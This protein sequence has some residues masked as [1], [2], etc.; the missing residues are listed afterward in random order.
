MYTSLGDAS[1]P[2]AR[3]YRFF[4]HPQSARLVHQHFFTICVCAHVGSGARFCSDD[5]L[6]VLRLTVA[7]QA[8][9][10]LPA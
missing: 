4:C 7:A 1:C 9:L 10:R 6:L 8:L 3:L 2:A 5:E